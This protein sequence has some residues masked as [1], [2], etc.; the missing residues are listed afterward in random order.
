[1]RIYCLSKGQLIQLNCVTPSG[2]KV[3][4]RRDSARSSICM[5]SSTAMLLV[6]LY[7]QS[8]A[9]VCAAAAA[10]AHACMHGQDKRPALPRMHYSYGPLNISLEIY[11]SRPLQ[12]TA[13]PR[14]APH[15]GS[16]KNYTRGSDWI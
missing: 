7:L 5:I 1:V 16:I 2:G 13:P 9:H 15:L 6:D 3:V 10:A 4:A 8:A 12:H 14:T 11:I